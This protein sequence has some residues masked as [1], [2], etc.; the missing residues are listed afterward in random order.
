MLPSGDSNPE[1]ALEC[2]APCQ[3]RSAMI[4]DEGDEMQLSVLL[5]SLQASMHEARLGRTLTSWL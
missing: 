1:D 3:L 4:A 5:K 2:V